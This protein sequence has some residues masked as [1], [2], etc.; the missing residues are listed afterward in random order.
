M[1]ILLDE[2]VPERVGPLL[3]GHTWSSVRRDGWA[4]LKNGRLLA[5][6]AGSFDVL[7][8]ADKNIEFQQN[9]TTLPLAVIILRAP[10]NRLDD[11]A[12]VVPAALQALQTL[13]PKTLVSVSA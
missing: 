9:L 5:V 7:L 12:K 11:L 13:Q 3:A 4:G 10:S 2:A 8:T 6:A 1:R